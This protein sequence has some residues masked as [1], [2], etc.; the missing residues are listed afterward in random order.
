MIVE[1]ET[2]MTNGEFPPRALF[3]VLEWRSLYKSELLED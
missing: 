1:I 3:H 2:G